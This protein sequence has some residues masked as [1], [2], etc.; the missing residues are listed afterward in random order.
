MPEPRKLVLCTLLCVCLSFQRSRSQDLLEQA[1]LDVETLSSK[2]MCGRG[3]VFDGLK[4]AGTFL[5]ARFKTLG[6]Q[7]L[8][9]D[10]VQ[11]FDM[12]VNTFDAPP[13]LSVNREPCVLGRDFLPYATSGSGNIREGT[14]IFYLRSGLFL[15]GHGVND[16]SGVTRR[17][18]VLI[19]SEEVPEQ[20][21][22]DTTIDRGL[23]AKETRIKLALQLQPSAILVLVKRL[24]LASPRAQEDVPILDVVKDRI[25]SRISSVSLDVKAAFDDRESMNVVGTL[26]GKITS[27]SSI[28][29]CAHFDHLGGFSDSAYFPGANDNASGTAMLLSLAAYFKAHPINASLIFIATSGEEEGLLG[30]QYYA[31]HPL[32]DLD[33]TKFLLNFDIVGSGDGGIMVVGG[34]NFPGEFSV[35]SALCDSL[36]IKPL[37]KR[38]TAPNSDHY[39]FS[40]KGVKTFYLYT[41]NGKQPYHRFDD[42]C[43]T[44]DWGAFLNVFRLSTAFI[45]HMDSRQ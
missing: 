32:H 37:G 17:G 20:F 6:L 30:S 22:K 40:T 7:P 28:V 45:E 4:K 27:D 35:M 39:S 38:P 12:K 29:V 8:G 25:P 10:Y 11:R 26:P 31:E 23:L 3:Y 34:E 9:E 14:D 1:R 44:L 36:K 13:E 2:E 33:K 41:M 16:Y 24:G 18:A 15:P 42:I 5:E 21:I 43:A 19:F